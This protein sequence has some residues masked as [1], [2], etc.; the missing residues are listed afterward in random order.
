MIYHKTKLGILYNGDCLK[1]MSGIKDNYFSA[2]VTDPPYGLGFMGKGWDKGVPGVLYW[3]EVFRVCKPGSFLLAFG[4]TRTFHRLTCAIEDAGWEIRDCISWLY[5]TGFPKSHDISKAIDKSKGVKRKVVGIK[6]GKGG[7][8]I[9]TLSRSSGCDSVEAKG[10]GSYGVGAKQINI[11]I[12]VTAPATPESQEWDGYGTALK[13]AWEPII[14]AMKPTDGTFVHNALKHGVAGLNIDECR[15][16]TDEKLTRKLGKTTQSCSGWKSVNRSEI[17]GKDGGRWPANV[18]LD[19]ESGKMLDEQSGVTR[20]GK[21]KSSKSSYPGDGVTPFIRGN[22]NTDNQHGDTGG[23]SRF[24]YCVKSSKSERNE[25]LQDIKPKKRDLVRSHGQAGTDNAYNRE[26]TEVKNNHPTV[27]PLKLM[28]YLCKLTTMPQGGV[29]FDPF[30][31]SGTTL[32]ACEK[33]GREWTGIELE[34]E[35]CEIIKLRIKNEEN[36]NKSVNTFFD[37]I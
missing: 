16:D 7:E 11:E 3:K 4:G 8:N 13:P 19:E 37:D 30:A 35:Y 6:I 10:L 17:A 18:I 28:E 26:A 14:V 20:S 25:G 27:K 29:I 23:A 36:K 5:G 34:Q 2:V 9:N 31:G 12:P 21:V 32:L 24:F 33:S 1:V 22:T 15:I